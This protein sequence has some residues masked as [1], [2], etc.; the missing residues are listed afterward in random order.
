MHTPVDSLDNIN[1]RDAILKNSRVNLCRENQ[2][3]KLIA[4]F[5]RREEQLEGHRLYVKLQP[6]TQKLWQ[7]N[8]FRKLQLTVWAET[9]YAQGCVLWHASWTHPRLA[10]FSHV[11]M[12]PIQNE[13]LLGQKLSPTVPEQLHKTYG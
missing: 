2:K 12:F 8:P 11:F 3:M 10:K 6:T 4:H 5:R 9:Y 7:S 1:D 13:A